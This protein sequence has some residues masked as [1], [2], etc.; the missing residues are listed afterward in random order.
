MIATS[1]RKTPKSSELELSQFIK[2]ASWIYDT[3]NEVVDNINCCFSL[4]VVF[5]KL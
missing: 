5:L 1:D 4:Q 3:L 2:K